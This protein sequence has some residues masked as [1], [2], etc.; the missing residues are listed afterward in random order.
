MQQQDLALR[1]AKAEAKSK[2]TTTGALIEAPELL[3]DTARIRAELHKAFQ[4]DGTSNL[5]KICADA[6]RAENQS[7]RAKIATRLTKDKSEIGQI[8]RSYSHVTDQ[9][10][11]IAHEVATEFLHPNPNPSKAERLSVLAVGGYGRSEMAPFSDVDILFL[12]PLKITPWAEQVVESILYIL[13]DV[14][15]NVGHASRSIAECIKLGNSDQTIKT[16][17]IEAR[18]LTGD[19]KTFAK[20]DTQLWTEI[21]K[22]DQSAYV[23]EK[24]DERAARHERQGQRYMLEPNVKE[25]K[26]GLR[27]LQSMYWITKYVTGAKRSSDMIRLGYLSVEEFE[28]FLN[29]HRFLWLVRVH[30]HLT[31]GR[32]V[33]QLTFDLQTD[34]AERLGYKPKDGQRRVEVFMQDYF[35]HATKV[36]ELTRIYLTALED[37]HIKKIPS[38]ADRMRTMLFKRAPEQHENP[39]YQINNE[40]IDLADTDAFLARPLNILLLFQDALESGRLIHPQAMRV[41]TANLHLID[42]NMRNDP[43]AQDIF[44][45]L[46]L[47]YGNPER[48]LRRMNELGVLGAF[49]PEFARIQ[50]MMQFNSYHSYTVDEHIIQCIAVLAKIEAGQLKEELPIVSGIL[51]QGVNR[52]VL[53]VALLLHDIGKGLPEDHTTIGAKLAAEIA[54][55]LGLDEAKVETVI[56]LVENHLVM[57]DFAQKRDLSDPR[58][59]SGFAR[60]V[61]STSRLNLLAALTTCDI[62]GVGPQTLTQ[63]KA[64]L[65]R[66]LYGATRALISGG[67]DETGAYNPTDAAKTALQERLS[68]WAA[69]D[70]AAECARHYDAYWK[71]LDTDAHAQIAA[72]IPKVVA[73]D[74][75]TAFEQDDTRNATRAIF[76][77]EDHPGIFA[78][79]AGA[80][81]LSNANVVDARTYTSSDGYA[82]PVFW[83]QDND[84]K[85]FES[86]RLKRLKNAVSRILRGEVSAQEALKD[87]GKLKKREADFRVP[88]EIAIDN[89][90]SELYTIIEVDTRDRPSLLYDL[91]RTIS[92][93][94]LI[95]ASAVI[96]TYGAQAVDVFYVKD[97]FGLKLHSKERQKKIKD[98]LMAAIEAGARA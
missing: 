46:L 38:F 3:F 86:G 1:P 50:A 21:G 97:M 4:S 74:F 15:L 83:I 56:W 55:L 54:P 17:L 94:N 12:T 51:K 64:Q 90:G 89:L 23:Q 65:L 75:Q 96:A 82:T 42:D 72:L 53:Y 24:L 80:L 34:L 88:T 26:G 16:A 41:V 76:V 36:G 57:S 81:A 13:W 66:D 78:R 67:L 68:D 45:S 5:R 52:R 18:H 9:I 61:K 48:A 77:L 95:I 91:S 30:L 79:L 69:G 43:K 73:G 19:I 47:D 7:A 29:A 31:A 85:P 44:L 27:D 63:W 98:R 11:Q 70:I 33:E 59:V 39:L 10:V 60:I 22:R 37:Q 58:T 14:K 28:A 32:A 62:M 20:F 84:G 8:I 2:K 40:R 71:G 6:L 35:R 25:G 92:D 87:H 49:I 93:N